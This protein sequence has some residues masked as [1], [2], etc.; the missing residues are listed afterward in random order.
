M[1]Q[2]RVELELAPPSRGDTPSVDKT[3]PPGVELVPYTYEQLVAFYEGVDRPFPPGMSSF[4]V[5]D[6][7]GVLVLVVAREHDEVAVR[8]FLEGLP[9]DAV[10]VRIS[11]ERWYA[12]EAE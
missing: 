9:A 6:E 12:N 3:D 4:G 2:R 1:L 7:A 10:S 8:A 5:D 11:D